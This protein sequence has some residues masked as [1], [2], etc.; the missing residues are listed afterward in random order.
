MER[1]G[2]EHIMCQRE[3]NHI[4]N[5]NIE[6]REAPAI[7]GK[8]L[9]RLNEK[10]KKNNQKMNDYVCDKKEKHSLGMGD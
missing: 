9:D 2:I 8:D 1:R 6:L 4:S 3:D 10:I 7:S 5:Q